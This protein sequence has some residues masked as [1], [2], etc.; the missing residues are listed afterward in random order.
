MNFP[1]KGER[2]AEDFQFSP[3]HRSPLLGNE[4]DSGGKGEGEKQILL[5]GEI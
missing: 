1:S 4:T 3:H 5:E 2:L